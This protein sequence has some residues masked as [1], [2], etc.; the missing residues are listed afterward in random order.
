MTT[1][2]KIAAFFD[3]DG[4]LARTSLMIDHFLRLVKNEV[5]RENIWVNDIKPLYDE[6]NKR[7]LDYDNY[8]DAVTGVYTETLKGIKHDFIDYVAQQV[9]EQNADI[10]YTYTRSRIR[11]HKAQG[12][13]TFFISGSPDF[14]VRHMAK[15][16]DVTDFQGTIYHVNENDEFTGEYTK[17]WDS[18]SKMSMMH[19]FDEI[20][21][22]DFKNSY[23]YG[24][25]NG[26]I[27]MLQFV[28][29]PVVINP[30]KK[31][32]EF[33]QSDE[34]LSSKI[35]IVVERKDVVYKLPPDVQTLDT[36]TLL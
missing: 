35:E 1:D 32:L 3:I 14:L 12:H 5:I 36:A 16:Y 18:I 21:G 2:K 4:T 23:A 11:W 30:T 20:Y 27:S 13:L 28:G 9:I 6:Y 8:L 22:I 29:H 17:M 26:D 19:S 10:V 7:H 15:K 31:L 24:D 34:D 25:T 33:I